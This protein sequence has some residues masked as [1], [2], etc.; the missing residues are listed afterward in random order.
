MKQDECKY[1]K[2]KGIRV[3]IVTISV[4]DGLDHAAQS[5]RK[6]CNQSDKSQVETQV[7]IG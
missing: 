1:G 3:Y 7:Q 5:E 2:Q 4:L 6:V